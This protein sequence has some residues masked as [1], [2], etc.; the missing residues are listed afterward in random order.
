MFTEQKQSDNVPLQTVIRNVQKMA[1]DSSARKIA[2]S[3]SLAIN[4]VS[5]EDCARN[6]FSVW[7]P[8]ISDMTL[9]VDNQR[10]P[11]IREPNYT[12]KTWDVETD[13]IPVVVGNHDENPGAEL[14]TISLREY[15]ENFHKYMSTPPK[16]KKP[17]NLLAN[18]MFAKQSD[19]HVIMSSQCCFLPIEKGKETKF[20][21]ALFNYQSKKQDPAV[22]V[23]VSTSKGT[24]AQIIEGN[25]QKLLFNNY[26]R[27][28]DFI[29]QRLTD[30]RIER[31]VSIHGAMTK[32]EKQDNCIVIIQVPLKQKPKQIHVHHTQYE[33]TSPFTSY[34]AP[35][36]S[37]G[38]PN[39]NSANFAFGGMGG[40]LGAAPS[41]TSSSSSWSYGAANNN[42]NSNAYSND[43]LCD[44]FGGAAPPQAAQSSFASAQPQMMYQQQ[45]SQSLSSFQDHSSS[46][47]P[48][49][50]PNKKQ[51]R[52]K[53]KEDANVEAAIVKIAGK[54]TPTCSCGGDLEEVELRQCYPNSGGG[55]NCDGCGKAV[56]G[57]Y[58][59]LWHCPL[60]KSSWK[61]SNG[62]DLCK[63]CGEKQ[64]R[65]EELNGMQTIERD[66]R[67]PIRVTLQYYK[68]TDNGVL[69][70]DIMKAIK[71]LLQKSQKQADYIG[72]LV[73][74][75]TVRSTEPDLVTKNK[76]EVVH[77]VHKVQVPVHPVWTVQPQPDPF[78]NIAVWPQA[79]ENYGKYS[80]V[81]KALQGISEKE[82]KT[83]LENFKAQEVTDD[84]LANLCR[85]DLM[86]LIPKM[87]PRNRFVKW[88]QAEYP[89]DSA[90]TNFMDGFL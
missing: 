17:I 45:Q 59:K 58:T 71:T 81:A 89:K 33:Y 47:D 77:H 36:L 85:Q 31:G 28:A 34:N 44:A 21:V 30:N 84:D 3:H 55:V 32:Q 40:N 90:D 80:K 49:S 8:C 68:S 52:K 14:N 72:S 51:K 19:K 11:V 20:N 29:G 7:G 18:D 43:L 5:Y 38:A 26:G 53:K 2:Q 63:Q 76:T 27:K 75:Y 42:S 74:D 13:K 65:F 24:S 15:L 46:F 60:E 35:S 50:A 56:N 39:N 22:L 87:G 54:T 67:Y 69:T 66:T 10:M 61:H 70:M 23:I 41:T 82:W 25:E 73:T 57:Q 16:Q 88:L 4:T 48:F 12:D 1:S 79:T 86:E 83:Y 62:Y 37:W 78:A 9:Q 64:L 6:K